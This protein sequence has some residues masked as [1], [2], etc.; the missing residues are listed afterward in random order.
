MEHDAKNVN[1]N[2]GS[3][4]ILLL[5]YLLPTILY[6]FMYYMFVITKSS[7]V[8]D[9]INSAC[10]FI[11]YGAMVLID[12]ILLLVG[13]F[14]RTFSVVIKRLRDFFADL[15]ISFKLAN[16][17]YWNSVKNDGITFWLYLLAM[18]GHVALAIYGLINHIEYL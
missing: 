5:M 4:L 8:F 9:Y 1:V 7:F 12:F 2:K 14:K 11:S 6:F 17:G 13:F 18:L 3:W 16:K 10:I 15:P